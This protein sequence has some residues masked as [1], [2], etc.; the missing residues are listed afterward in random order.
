[1]MQRGGAALPPP[2]ER[3]GSC[4]K[5]AIEPASECGTIVRT[6]RRPVVLDDAKGSQATSDPDRDLVAG[7][8]N[9]DR[10][11]FEA[12]LRRHYDRVHR[13]AWR[14]T[15]SRPDADDLAQEVCC[16]LV[17]KISSFKGE[18][19][20][21]TW[22]GRYHGER[23]PR[24]SPA[25]HDIGA[26][27]STACRNWSRLAA[28]P[29]GRDMYRQTW[30]A[31]DIARLDPLLR[32]TVLLV[33]GED[34]THAEAARVLGVAESTVSW[35]IH[36]ARRHLA[37]RMQEGS[38]RWLLS[39]TCFLGC[40]K[41]PAPS[42]SRGR[43]RSTPPCGASTT[44]AARPPRIPKVPR[45]SCGR[46][47][48]TGRR[49][50]VSAMPRARHLI[51]ASVVCLL[52]GSSAWLYVSETST[53]RKPDGPPS[54]IIASPPQPATSAVPDQS[55][56]RSEGRLGSADAAGI[57]CFASSAAARCAADG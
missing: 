30:L 51:A 36:E 11:A 22:L 10:A 48:T 32:D 28:L 1:M 14:L 9:G 44:N 45:V 35:R 4:L 37:Q 16:T 39:R 27:S 38:S 24:S 57:V 40:L 15:G 3:D 56:V 41:P 46:R 50:G 5:Q 33:I 52:A 7:A 21:A 20:F 8:R 25:R 55:L 2:G 6:V 43:P 42:P 47:P 18:A 53:R 12:L 29:D 34:L 23:L 13:L 17:E 49:P 31:S 54:P 26:L 19:K